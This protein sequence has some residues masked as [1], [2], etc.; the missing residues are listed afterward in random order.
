[1]TNQQIA[2]F[3]LILVGTIGL[4]LIV[5]SI[6]IKLICKLNNSKCTEHTLGKVVSYHHN[7][8]IITPIVEYTVNNTTYQ[9]VKKYNGIITNNISG[10]PIKT[11]NYLYEDENN[12]LHINKGPISNVRYLAQ[13][14]LPIGSKHDIY[15]DPTNPKRNY[16]DKATNQVVIRTIFFYIGIFII[17]LALL[18]FFLIK[19]KTA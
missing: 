13:Q 18:V 3:E 19:N 7:G 16:V 11:D 12:Y 14:Y 15:Y 2:L 6:V 1:M 10:L 17:L 5:A 8:E 4:L 9:T